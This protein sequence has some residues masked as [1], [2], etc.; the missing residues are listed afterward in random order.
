MVSNIEDVAR[1]AGV[2]RGTVSN[3]LNRPEKVAP[4][5]REKVLDAVSKLGYVPNESARVLAGGLGR[6]VGIVVH[7]ASNPYF[8]QIIR[9][10]EDLALTK[11]YTVTVTSTGAETAREDMALELLLQQ[12]AQG[13]LIT[14]ATIGVTGAAK[15]RAIGTSVVLLDSVGAHDECSVSVDDF[16]GGRLAA[17]HFIGKNLRRFAFVGTASKTTQH[18]DRLAGFLSELGAHG[19]GRDA[20]TVIEVPHEDVDSGRSAA[21]EIRQEA[22]AGPLAVFCGNDLIAVGISFELEDVDRTASQRIAVCGYDDI[23]FAAYLSN[24]LTSIRQPMTEIGRTAFELL[25]DEVTNPHH[26]HRNVQ[27]TPSLVARQSTEILV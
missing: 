3:V 10:I 5:T 15:L 26:E 8:A 21:A 20:V 25:L 22:Q 1:L 13:V 7:D 2:A 24:P 18:R 27:F 17:R 12:R 23:D 9:A 19:F 11:K 16:E 4:A 6:F 14:P